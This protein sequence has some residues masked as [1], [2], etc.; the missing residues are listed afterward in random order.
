[1]SVSDWSDLSIVM[2]TANRPKMAVRQLHRLN[3]HGAKLWVLDG[4]IEKSDDLHSI[5]ATN[6]GIKVVHEVS[7]SERW[8]CLNN[9][10]TDFVLIVNDDHL[11]LE[12]GISKNLK[13]LRE[14]RDIELLLN[15]ILRVTVFGS[16]FCFR[17]YTARDWMP[18]T[19][20]TMRRTIT[21]K[22]L[23]AAFRA[24]GIGPGSAVFEPALDIVSFRGLKNKKVD[25]PLEFMI[26]T[27]QELGMRTGYGNWHVSDLS[28][29]I[30]NLDFEQHPG[31]QELKAFLAEIELPEA[32]F[33]KYLR[34][35]TTAEISQRGLLSRAYDHLLRIEQAW[36]A[37]RSTQPGNVLFTDYLR[38]WYQYLMYDRT[39]E[40][41]H[42]R[43]EREEISADLGEICA[44]QA[45]LQSAIR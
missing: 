13:T 34:S 33:L 44:V 37:N 9:V 4:S 30:I 12:S 36:L 18:I 28:G 29:Q 11:F 21:L 3:K 15:P 26:H 41:Y 35:I 7:T 39:A 24:V 25:W 14:N 20:Y 40:D 31:S 32:E 19:F 10:E 17:T 6:R 1:M 27:Q 8:L 23:C 5:A 22:K 16:R 42:R 2:F 43:L 38:F 45:E